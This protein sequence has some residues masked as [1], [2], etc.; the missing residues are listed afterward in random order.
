MDRFKLPA[1]RA[2]RA[3][4][5]VDAA[6]TVTAIADVASVTSL[7]IVVLEGEPHRLADASATLAR[8]GL[9]VAPDASAGRPD[10]LGYNKTVSA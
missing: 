8:A 5:G 7:Q 4:L 3:A 6:E 9:V 1:P 2:L 10:V